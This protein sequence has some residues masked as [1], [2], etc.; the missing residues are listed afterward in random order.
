MKRK[1]DNSRRALMKRLADIKRT[2]DAQKAADRRE[3]RVARTRTERRAEA[4][5]ASLPKNLICPVCI[6]VKTKSRQWVVDWHEVFK[7]TCKACKMKLENG[8]TPQQIRGE[9]S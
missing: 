8:W 2:L 7:T 3:A 4:R 1:Y 9:E 5:L 6:Q